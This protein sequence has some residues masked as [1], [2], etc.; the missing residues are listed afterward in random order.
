MKQTNKSNF[1]ELIPKLIQKSKT[2]SREIKNRIKLNHI[3]SEFE[4]KASNQFNFFIKESEKRYLGS[5]YGSKMDYL[6]KSS[7]K[8]GKKEANKI[9]NDNFY[10]NQDILSERKKMLK[11]STNEVHQNIGDIISKI[12]GV[13]NYPK[14][15]NIQ[16]LNFKFIS[17]DKEKMEKNK[18]EINN[19]LNKE[20]EKI[21]KSFEQ[22]RNI[23][24]KIKPGPKKMHTMEENETEENENNKIKKD[25]HFNIPKMELL[26]Y[27]KP[28][29][30]I[31][32]KKEEDDENRININ[33][34]IPYTLS[35]KN[36]LPK[37]KEFCFINPLLKKDKDTFS[38]N[39]TNEIVIRKAFN[40]L[41]NI[42][43][44]KYRNNEITKK[45]GIGR[46][47]NLTIYETIIKNNYNKVKSY[48]NHLNKLVFDKQKFVGI[49]SRDKLN[50]KIQDNLNHIINFEKNYL[51]YND[52]VSI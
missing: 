44:Y 46:I 13:K 25:M 39:S 8:R 11:K 12:K 47:P 29:L 24:S 16:S 1:H 15:N 19:I 6:L 2:L 37:N 23:L 22:Y 38:F 45:L 27:T 42:N 51:K 5:K 49:S 50:Y 33:K 34:L 28:Y 18:N 43:K 48:R 31:K 4:T 10:L 9:L 20:E 40:E 41:N 30:H 35:G 26:N 21:T 14:R 17:E 32:T 36:L 3:F 7:Q 52:T